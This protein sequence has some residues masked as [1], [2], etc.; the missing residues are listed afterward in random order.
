MG[1]VIVASPADT[2]FRGRFEKVIVVLAG[3]DQRRPRFLQTKILGRGIE[4]FTVTLARNHGGAG[5]TLQDGGATRVGADLLLDVDGIDHTFTMVC[6]N[7][8]TTAY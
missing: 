1:E 7:T 4:N 5:E 8:F 2:Q 6:Q 3:D